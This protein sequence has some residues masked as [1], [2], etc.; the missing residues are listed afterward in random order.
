ML[1]EHAQR[2]AVTR[3]LLDIDQLEPL[4]PEDR[5]DGMER[6]VREVLVVDRVVLEVLDQLREVR[7]L[8]RRCPSRPEQ[9]SHAGDEVVD[10]GHLGENVVSENK[11]GVAPLRR[12][13]AFPAR[14]RRTR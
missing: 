10:I 4:R 3:Q 11:V 12:Q 1:Q 2:A 14:F 7:E 9:R 13:G 6:E 5:T 8:E